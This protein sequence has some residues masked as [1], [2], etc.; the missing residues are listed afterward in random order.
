MPRGR[1]FGWFGWY[2]HPGFTGYGFGRGNPYPFCRNFPW[3]PRWW[4]TGMYGPISPWSTYPGYMYG[5]PY[6][7]M[8]YSYPYRG[9]GIY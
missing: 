8:P 2:G 5:Y 6:Y 7:R 1:G 3:M 9:Y 4:W